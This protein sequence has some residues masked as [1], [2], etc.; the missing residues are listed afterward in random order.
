M[1]QLPRI[2]DSEWLVMKVLWSSS[3]ATTT[4]VVE[5]LTPTIKWKLK[6]VLTLLNRL[7]K[8]GAVGYDKV[9]RAYHYYPLV[10]EKDCVR[11]ENRSFLQRVYGGSIAPMLAHF[12]EDTKLSP[13]QI[14][15]LKD[16]LERKGR[17]K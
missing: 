15:E 5:A 13:S 9:G 10:S 14:Q 4:D 7:V 6:T 17:K 12:V 8:K 1:A 16:I 11:A 2:S 3:P